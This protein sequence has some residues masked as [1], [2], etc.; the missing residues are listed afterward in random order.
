M[1]E[2]RYYIQIGLEDIKNKIF[3]VNWTGDCEEIIIEDPCCPGSGVT[4]INC[5]TGTTYVYSSMT[6]LLSGGTNGTS[7]LTGL[8]IPIMLT[9]TTYDMGW[10][11]VFD[12][13]VYQKETLNNFIYSSD[14]INPY[15]F[16]VFNTSNNV[17]QSTYEVNWGD[18]S[19]SVPINTFSPSSVS[20]TYPATNGTYTV[21]IT[22]TTPWGIT[23]VSKTITVPYVN[24]VPLNPNGTVTFFPQGGNWNNIPIS[25]DFLFTGDSNTNIIDY[26]SSSYVNIPFIVSGYTTSALADLEQYGAIPYPI[27][28]QVTGETG[29]VG[30]YYGAVPNNSYSAYTINGVDYWDLSGG[31]TLYFVQSSGLT[32]D[33]IVFSAITKEEA[34]I[35]VAYE[36]EIRSDIFIERGRVS[37]LE[38]IMRLGEVDNIGDLVKYG[39]G[40]FNVET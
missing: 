18:G 5:E 36:P 35:G 29:V 9:Q 2:Q 3:P 15:T 10:Y 37:A 23:T 11:S 20:H 28:V 14:T 26:I 19:P 22:G 39:Y 31:T 13:L 34:L 1:E 12:G 17:I 33:D 32:I 30:T 6:Q 4:Y 8:T 38:S 7:T 21:T 27:G 25:Y 24:V 16:Y 40:F